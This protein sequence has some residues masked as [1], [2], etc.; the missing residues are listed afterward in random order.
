M[1]LTRKVNHWALNNICFFLHF[2][3]TAHLRR[4][5][6]D[7]QLAL[8]IPFWLEGGNQSLRRTSLKLALGVRD[9]LAG[10]LGYCLTAV[11]PLQEASW[12]WG[13]PIAGYLVS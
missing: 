12:G 4:P 7:P 5:D 10:G 6:S 1:L 9:C 8:L 3:H 2:Q 13:W 11:W